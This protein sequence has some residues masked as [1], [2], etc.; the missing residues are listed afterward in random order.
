MKKSFLVAL[1][2]AGMVVM[3]L[4]FTRDDPK[5]KNLKILPKNI[6]KEQMDSVMH[7]FTGSL[8]VKCSF[9]HVRNEQA[10]TTEFASD[11]NKH[12]LVA[13]EMM[14]MTKHLNDKYFDVVGN[15]KDPLS[16]KLMVTCYTCHHGQTDPAVTPPPRERN[17]QRQVTD[18][19]RR[20]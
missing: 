12:K 10:G 5:Y 19:T 8:N 1:G 17:N 9:C 3:C 7:H 6:T 11:D 15:K 16:V 2:L 14:K 18:S 20:N 4:A 13:R